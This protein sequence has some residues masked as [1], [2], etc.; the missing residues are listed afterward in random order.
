MKNENGFSS[1]IDMGEDTFKQLIQKCFADNWKEKMDFCC[2]HYDLDPRSL[3]NT[4]VDLCAQMY[5]FGAGDMWN[6]I[7]DLSKEQSDYEDYI[8]ELM[9]QSND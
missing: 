9:N 5:M 7:Y 2:S 1:E 8:N 6:A 4:V 3:E